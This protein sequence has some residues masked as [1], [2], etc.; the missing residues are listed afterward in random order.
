MDWLIVI[1]CAVTF[2]LL[3]NA[4]WEDGYDQAMNDILKRAIKDQERANART[5]LDNQA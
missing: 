3:I 1:L 4:I 2:V 5:R